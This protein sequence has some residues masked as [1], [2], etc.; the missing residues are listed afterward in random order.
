MRS[1]EGPAPNRWAA[2]LGDLQFWIPFATFLAGVGLL[3]WI[4]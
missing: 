3:Q 1:R 2:T 4:K